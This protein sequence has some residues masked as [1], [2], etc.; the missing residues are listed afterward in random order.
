MLDALGSIIENGGY[1]PP[2]TMK[3]ISIGRMEMSED[4]RDINVHYR[5]VRDSPP[6]AS[7][8]AGLREDMDIDSLFYD[9]SRRVIAVSSLEIENQRYVGQSY[10]KVRSPNIRELEVYSEE[11]DEE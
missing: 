8:I 3:C 1:L 4:G 2:S 11:V 9:M 10:R 6:G 5:L 7:R